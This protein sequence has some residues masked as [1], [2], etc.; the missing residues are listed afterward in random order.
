MR[1]PGF[2]TEAHYNT[3][4]TDKLPVVP[5]DQ[6]VRLIWEGEFKHIKVSH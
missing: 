4:H 2:D 3:H 5:A 6:L 1:G